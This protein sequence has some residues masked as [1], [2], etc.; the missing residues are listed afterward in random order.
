MALHQLNTTGL[1]FFKAMVT[2]LLGTVITF[3][4]ACAVQKLRADAEKN[5]SKENLSF[6]FGGGGYIILGMVT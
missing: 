5:G 6:F 2:H 4:F 1:A 3:L